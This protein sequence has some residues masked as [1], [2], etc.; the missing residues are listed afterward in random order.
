ML[1]LREDTANFIL[2]F[3]FWSFGSTV[4]TCWPVFHLFFRK[5]IDIWIDEIID[6]EVVDW[7]DLFSTF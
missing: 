5:E 7:C 1:F 6:C 3:I 4:S 2:C